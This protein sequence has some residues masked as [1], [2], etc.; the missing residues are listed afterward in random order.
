MD[1]RCYCSCSWWSNLTNVPTDAQEQEQQDARSCN[2]V[3][4]R[5]DDIQDYWIPDGQ[6]EP[7]KVF[8]D[9]KLPVTLGIV[10]NSFGEDFEI[11]NATK[12]G[13]DMGLF[14][15]AIHG[16]NHVSYANLSLAEQTQTMG[17]ATDLLTEVYGVPPKIFIPPFN[18]FNQDTIDAMKANAIPILSADPESRTAPPGNGHDVYIA[19]KGADN[20]TIANSGIFHLPQTIDFNQHIGGDVIKVELDEIIFEV[21]KAITTKGY[22]VVVLHPTDFVDSTE[23]GNLDEDEINDLERLID[24]LQSEGRNIVSFE[25]VR[26]FPK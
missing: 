24:I 22:A 6:E 20:I 10:T 1:S 8:E 5:F 4:F 23:S 12:T 25:D 15:P 9:K 13:V 18:D 7:L 11:V 2:C 3:V 14:E 16:W 19:K 21:N 26:N 17:N